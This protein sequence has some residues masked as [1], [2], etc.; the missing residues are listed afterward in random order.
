MNQIPPIILLLAFILAPLVFGGFLLVLVRR[1]G[2][3]RVTSIA[4]LSAGLALVVSL[5]LLLSGGTYLWALHLEGKWRAADPKT[6]A[7]LESHLALYTARRIS[8]A[9]SAGNGLHPF[10]PDE[11]MIRYSL[12]GEPLDVVFRKDDTIAAIYT[13]YE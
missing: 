2:K 7:D 12:L 11:R 10:Q 1:P 8:P 13:T 3:G 5:F 9:E 4:G 6:K